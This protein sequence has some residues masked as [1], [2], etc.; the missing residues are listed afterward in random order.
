MYSKYIL[1]S[2]IL[3]YFLCYYF[4]ACLSVRN[5]RYISKTITIIILLLLLLLLLKLDV[6]AG[7]FTKRLGTKADFASKPVCIQR[8]KEKDKKT[9]GWGSLKDI[10]GEKRP[11]M[12]EENKVNVCVFVGHGLRSTSFVLGVAKKSEVPICFART[13]VK[14]PSGFCQTGTRT[15]VGDPWLFKLQ[16]NKHE[17]PVNTSSPNTHRFLVLQIS[18]LHSER[19]QYIF[20]S[21]YL[22]NDYWPLLHVCRFLYSL[23]KK[24]TG[25]TIR[26][27]FKHTWSSSEDFKDLHCRTW[28]S[29]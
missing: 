19:R 2:A 8:K 3:Y 15:T 23:N 9:V 16:R 18:P 6:D 14:Y 12:V 5:S 22:R 24:V 1:F 11:W 29:F 4:K 27:L 28:R 20:F 25:Q 13:F 26:F 7:R 17:L 10:F 21:L